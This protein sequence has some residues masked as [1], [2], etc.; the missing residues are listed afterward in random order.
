[1][2]DIPP[3]ADALREA[4]VLSQEALRNLE[5]SEIPLSNITLKAS[6]LARLLND[7]DYQQVFEYEA[8][9]YPSTPT[10]VPQIAWRLALL[11]GRHYEQKDESGVKTYIYTES[12]AQLEEQIMAARTG[13]EAARDPDV[14]VSSANPNQFVSSPMGNTLERQNLQRQLAIATSRLAARKSFVYHYILR[15]HYELKFSGIA[16][17]VFARI[18]ERADEKIGQIVPESI[19]RLAAVHEYLRSESSE[20]WSNAAHS[21]RRILQDLADA[22][23]PAQDTPRVTNGRTIKLGADNYINRLMCFAEDRSTSERYNAIVGSHLSFLGERARCGVSSCAEG[24]SYG[25]FEQRRGRPVCGL[26][27]HACG[28]SSDTP[29]R[30]RQ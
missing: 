22:L 27:L 4:L 25:Y 23:F 16:S 29:Q 12:I 10:G 3:T 8:G 6:R 21:C 24:L 26:Y 19:K 2:N 14:S 5:L 20:D 15:K 18:R 9:G 11:A 13:I 17:D 28:R 7:F 1:M 30:G